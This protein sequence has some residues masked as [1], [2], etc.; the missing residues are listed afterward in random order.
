MT[1]FNIKILA[2]ESLGVRSFASYIETP[3]LK[4]LIDPGCALGPISGFK[5]PHPLEYQK[6]EDKTNEIIEYA[7]KSD[8]IIISH[9]HNDHFKNWITDYDY[10]NTNSE[11]AESIYSN[12]ILFLKDSRNKINYS[13]KK[14]ADI[15]FTNVRTCCDIIHIS[16]NK[17]IEFGN[18]KIKF[19]EPIFHGEHKS[20][21]G[22]VIMTSIFDIEVG[23]T[24]TF[25]SDVQGP[26]IDKTLEYILK[27]KPDILFLD[28]K[29]VYNKSMLFSNN[30]IAIANSIN[31]IVIDHHF[32]RNLN[33]RDWIKK[34]LPEKSEQFCCSAEF[35]GEK[36]LQLEA[37]R[38]KLFKEYPISTTFLKW[39]NLK[40]SIRKLKKPPI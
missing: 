16:D 39:M 36:I 23:K 20:S 21:R 40:Q 6:L 17:N 30:L 11:I 12:K 14:R 37:L 29:K 13:Q 25:T 3:S 33:W 10:I 18:T 34:Y 8:V 22:W 24:I 5:I 28:G 35:N 7:K 2:A 1:N 27:I 4:I 32:L 19:S 15:F 38:Q 31:K 9:Y 26:V